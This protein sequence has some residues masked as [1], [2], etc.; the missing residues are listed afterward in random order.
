MMKFLTILALILLSKA[1]NPDNEDVSGVTPLQMNMLA[2]LINNYISALS[3][4]NPDA[5][6][7]ITQAIGG[8]K[9][10]ATFA[11]SDV[12]NFLKAVPTGSGFLNKVDSQDIETSNDPDADLGD[13]IDQDDNDTSG[14]GSEV[15]SDTD[16]NNSSDTGSVDG[17]DN[18]ADT[19]SNEQLDNDINDEI[20]TDTDSDS[21]NFA[22]NDSGDTTQ[23]TIS[24]I[25][26]SNTTSANNSNNS[27]ANISK[28][29]SNSTSIGS[30]NFVKLPVIGISVISL[31][32]SL[33]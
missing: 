15:S 10:P 25:S 14:S 17:S 20:Y 9:F 27:I 29:L 23:T 12:S 30:Y 13:D 1:Q 33:Q 8:P 16:F 5:Y 18:D 7:S 2:P 26:A 3:Q 6:E 32:I 22:E 24:R 21:I 28:S 31:I 4:S 11:L 19:E